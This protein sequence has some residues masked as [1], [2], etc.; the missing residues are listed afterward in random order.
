M[1]YIVAD[2]LTKPSLTTGTDS[3]VLAA[4]GEVGTFAS[5]SLGL[6]S[7]VQEVDVAITAVNS[8]AVTN[9]DLFFIERTSF[10]KVN[11]H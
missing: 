10:L 9:V 6:L 2:R 8:N 1:L 11:P 5:V 7:P 3:A 4:V